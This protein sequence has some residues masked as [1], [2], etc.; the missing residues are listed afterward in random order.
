V[1]LPSLHSY[2]AGAV[3]RLVNAQVR[4]FRNIVDSGVVEINSDVTAL[5]GK[6]ESGKT[7]F[8]QALY[9]LNPAYTDDFDELD[10]YPR[11]RLREDSLRMPDNTSGLGP[12]PS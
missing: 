1:W 12:Q 2:T 6:N 4:L 3:V 5:V 9:R 8:I 10:D 11:W 7:A